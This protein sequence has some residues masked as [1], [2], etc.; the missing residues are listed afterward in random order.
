MRN[1]ILRWVEASTVF[2]RDEYIFFI[3]LLVSLFLVDVLA[4]RT[5]ELSPRDVDQLIFGVY[6][7][8]DY[9]DQII[10]I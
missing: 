2:C 4:V 1:V 3:Y 8:F 6:L 10:L 5:F 9:F 7:I